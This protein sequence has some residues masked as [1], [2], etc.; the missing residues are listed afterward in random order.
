MLLCFKLEQAAKMA[1]EPREWQQYLG[2][3]KL[4]GDGKLRQVVRD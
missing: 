1:N 2:S 4:L 3:E